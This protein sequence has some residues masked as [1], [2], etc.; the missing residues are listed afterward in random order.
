M[1]KEKGRIF[2]SV[3]LT[4]NTS[5]LQELFSFLEVKLMSV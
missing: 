1:N 4:K 5:F 3:K 2:D